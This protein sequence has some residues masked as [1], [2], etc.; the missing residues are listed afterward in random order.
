M[1]ASSA[2]NTC[3]VLSSAEKLGKHHYPGVFKHSLYEITSVASQWLNP[4]G[5]VDHLQQS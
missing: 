1:E 5:A 2:S 3:R 4:R